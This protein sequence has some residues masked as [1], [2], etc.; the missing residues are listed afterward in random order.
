M[1]AGTYTPGF[2]VNLHYK[3]LGIVKDMLS[4]L[5]GVEI[6]LAEMTI[7]HY[8]TLMAQDHGDEDISALFRLKHNH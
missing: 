3:D 2:K 1:L 7:G 5:S 4:G 6:P 8:Q